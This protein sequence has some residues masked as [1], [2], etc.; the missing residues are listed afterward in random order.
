MKSVQPVW[1]NT[2]SSIITAFVVYTLAGAAGDII[3]AISHASRGLDIIGTIYDLLNGYYEPDVMDI[4]GT[5]TNI[6]VIVGYFMFL[7]KLS[8][9]SDLQSTYQDKQDVSKVRSGYVLMVIAAVIDFIPAL[10][11]IIAAILYVF[12]YILLISGFK[13]LSKSRTMH[14]DA[15]EGFNGLRSCTRTLLIGGILSIL[16]LIGDILNGIISICMFFA[17]KDHWITIREHGPIAATI[18]AIEMRSYETDKLEE[19]VQNPEIYDAELVKAAEHE[20]KI[21]EAA[22]PFME[23][24]MGYDDARIA[25]ILKNPS[26]HS[27]EVVYCCQ[28]ETAKRKRIREEN[29]NKAVE[30]VIKGFENSVKEGYKLL[31]SGLQKWWP[32]VAGAIAILIAILIVKDFTSDNSRYKRG[33]RLYMAG[34]YDRSVKLF[35]KISKEHPSYPEAQYNIYT[36]K[37]ETC[38][39]L[40]AAQAL[41]N[42]IVP[43]QESTPRHIMTQY[44]MYLING[45]LEPHIERDFDQ[46][47]DFLNSYADFEGK[48]YAGEV[49]FNSGEHY[50]DRAFSIFSDI[51]QKE[52]HPAKADGYLGIMYL[53][54]LGN[55]EK[56]YKKAYDYLLKAPDEPLFAVHKGDL[57]LYLYNDHQKAKDFYELAYEISNGDESIKIRLEAIEKHVKKNNSDARN[58]PIA[59]SFSCIH[60]NIGI[61]ITEDYNIY[62]GE[63]E[64]GDLIEGTHISP[65][66]NKSI[67][68]FAP[69]IGLYNG[70]AYDLHGNTI[71]TYD[72]T[73]EE[74]KVLQ[75]EK[76]KEIA[77]IKSDPEYRKSINAYLVGDRHNEL[78]GIVF[79]VDETYK[80]G[81]VISFPLRNNRKTDYMDAMRACRELGENWRL[82][83]I[84]EFKIISDNPG[85]RKAIG[86]KGHSCWADASNATDKIPVWRFDFSDTVGHFIDSK[87]HTFAVCEF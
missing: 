16:P 66:G 70:T 30:E 44:A 34:K 15:K 25:E 35:E 67:G 60:D 48:L 51:T 3:D 50:Y 19:I 65:Q 22:V 20:T 10:G 49:C 80:H 27:E 81:K 86:T 54:G 83:N 84:T 9:F 43:T 78:D 31:I 47:V 39:S 61:I 23:Q 41:T 12:S 1:K 42:A 52:D 57:A 76:R 33:Q 6:L 21:R 68:K 2:V 75:E 71:K 36:C 85:I 55:L 29:I 73:D 5:M 37:M 24:V 69:Q 62:I 11:S 32:A 14:P 40:G 87:C 58:R 72:W 4:L 56:D 18:Y 26:T 8:E 59:E 53:Y 77:R 45:E 17:I 13:A 38:D 28:L 46:G 7:N 79:W 74:A 63:I 82:P 64:N